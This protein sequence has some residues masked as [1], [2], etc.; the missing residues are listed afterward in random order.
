VSSR[1]VIGF[2]HTHT[3]TYLYIYIYI[4]IYIYCV[5][6]LKFKKNNAKLTGN[7]NSCDAYASDV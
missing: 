7:G 4:Y 6:H 1:A 3:H 5:I 2:I